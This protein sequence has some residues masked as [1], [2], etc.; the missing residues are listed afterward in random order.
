MLNNATD[1]EVIAGLVTTVG[2]MVEASG[3]EIT[4][5]KNADRKAFYIIDNGDTLTFKTSEEE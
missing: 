4:V 2:A 1:D 5:P 3:G